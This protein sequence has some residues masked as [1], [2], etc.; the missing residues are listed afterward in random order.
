MQCFIPPQSPSTIEGHHDAQSLVPD[1]IESIFIF[2]SPSSN[3]PS[4]C[5][6]VLSAPTDFSLSTLS[7]PRSRESSVQ[8]LYSP[9]RARRRDVEALRS[10]FVNLQPE[11]EIWQW[12]A[13]ERTLEDSVFEAS[14]SERNDRW[15][16]L[17]HRRQSVQTRK[18]LSTSPLPLEVSHR[19]LM[20]GSSRIYTRRGRRTSRGAS[21]RP[22]TPHPRMHIPML[23]F[24]VSFLSVDEATLHLLTHST[25]ESALFPSHT[26]YSDDSPQNDGHLHGAGKLRLLSRESCSVK[27]GCSVACDPSLAPS[28]PFVLP[29]LPLVRLWNFLG[30]IFIDG[31]KALKELWT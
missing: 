14:G 20:S 27:E 23:S 3:P 30:D 22:S 8:P 13:A 5:P 26:L 9:T 6:S 28:N 1:L 24:L 16:L 11:S 19:R 29:S 18:S 21:P 25:I 2:P 12:S 10:P 31:R 4:P 17:F 15:E 7:E